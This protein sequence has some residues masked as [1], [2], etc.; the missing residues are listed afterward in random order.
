[1]LNDPRVMRLAARVACVG[2]VV[3]MV[4]PLGRILFPYVAGEV[5]SLQFSALEAVLSTTIGFGLYA[6]F[7][8]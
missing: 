4:F 6:V 1:M 7:F 5:G 2:L 8:G 3:I